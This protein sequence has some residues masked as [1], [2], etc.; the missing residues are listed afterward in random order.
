MTT[1][2]ALFLAFILAGVPIAFALGAAALAGLWLIEGAPLRIV[3]SRIFGGIDN[4]SLL[5]IPFFILAGELMETGG[6]SQRLVNLA[7][8]IVGHL[9]GGLGF[10]DIAVA[11]VD[12][13]AGLVLALH[14]QLHAADP[15]LAPDDPAGPDRGVE[16]CKA[17]SAHG[18]LQ[19]L[20]FL[21]FELDA[22]PQI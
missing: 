21:S 17:W 10:R 11:L 12:A 5:A 20:P 16:Y 3:A 9:R 1:S 15:P 22:E 6:I 19:L 13:L 4:F 2:L 14:R 18:S 7:R 8:V